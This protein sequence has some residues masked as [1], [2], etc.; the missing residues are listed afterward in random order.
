[1]LELGTDELA[2]H[3]GLATQIVALGIEHLLLFGPRMK[4][5]R[6]ELLSRGF[7]GKVAHFDSHAE[8]ASA[9][10]AGLKSG[11]ALMIKGSR[12]MHMEEIWNIIRK[13]RGTTQ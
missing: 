1:M 7:A 3:S 4:A 6:D 12:G 10:D 8:L 9:L 13:K 2:L 5:L 11:D